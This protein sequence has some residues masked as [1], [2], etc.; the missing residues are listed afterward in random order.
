MKEF[1]QTTDRRV[2]PATIHIAAWIAYAGY[3]YA[4]N[5]MVRPSLLF[6]NTLLSLIPYCFTFYTVLYFFKR[7]SNFSLSLLILGYILLFFVLTLLAYGFIYRLLPAFGVVL[8]STADLRHFIQ[9]AVLGYVEFSVYGLLYV[10]ADRSIKKERELRRSHEL[11]AKIEQEKIQQELANALLK[12]N[13]LIAQAEKAQ[14]EY[15][16]LQSQINPH[17]LFNTL[18]VLYAQA[19]RFSGDLAENICKLGE[20]MRYSIRQ[21]E[22]RTPCVPLQEELDQLQT[23]I[24]INHLRFGENCYVRYSIEGEV[25]SHLIPPL[26][27]ITI[28]ENAFKYGELKDPDNPLSIHLLL[29]PGLLS[30]T[31]RNK[32]RAFATMPSSHHIGIRNINHRL[33]MAFRNRFKTSVTDEG[34]FYTFQLI[35][36]SV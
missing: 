27:M 20:I 25:S 32:K 13:E 16:Y 17:F 35:I 18:N 28:V 11:N 34:G 29:A 22:D 8:Y 21:V 23:F 3:I 24:D 19:S 10:Y 14:Y 26:A 6:V 4:T 7:Y 12:Q 30:F 15:A 9:A 36:R 5:Y 1:L 31:C 2:H 33:K